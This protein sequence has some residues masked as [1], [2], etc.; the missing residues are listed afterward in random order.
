MPKVFPDMVFVR[1]T[2]GPD[3][4]PEYRVYDGVLLGLPAAQVAALPETPDAL[5][6]GTGMENRVTVPGYKRVMPDGSVQWVMSHVDPNLA[7]LEALPGPGGWRSTAARDTWASIG[8]EV[9][10]RGVTPAEIE[11]AWPALF[12]AAKAEVLASLPPPTP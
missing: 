12:A 9:R 11:Y 7:M 1:V 10:K 8:V 6:V 3:T 5:V 2:A 4:A